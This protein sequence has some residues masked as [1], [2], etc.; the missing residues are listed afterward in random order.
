MTIY[1]YIDHVRRGVWKSTA[2]SG[3]PCDGIRMTIH[4]DEQCQVSQEREKS[5]TV[6]LSVHYSAAWALPATQSEA[7]TEPVI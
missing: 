2:D 6:E 7:Q 3:G 4:L 1:D 5:C